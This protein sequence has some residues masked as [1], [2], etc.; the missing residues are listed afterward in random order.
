M[1]PS[2]MRRCGFASGRFWRL[3]NPRR[4][5]GAPQASLRIRLSKPDDEAQNPLRV[6][7][8]TGLHVNS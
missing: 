6:S 5:L 8:T 7:V 2:G 3:T 1:S 4:D